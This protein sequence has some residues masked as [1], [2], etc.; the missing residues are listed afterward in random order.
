MAVTK[1]CR[2]NSDSGKKVENVQDRKKSCP[3]CS[4]ILLPFTPQSMFLTIVALQL[5]ISYEILFS[6]LG[7]GWRSLK[8]LPK[9][10]IKTVQA[11]GAF[12]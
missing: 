5:Q 11:L 9:S 12:R 4:H 2:K 8:L 10:F 3:C 7:P 1:P 6:I